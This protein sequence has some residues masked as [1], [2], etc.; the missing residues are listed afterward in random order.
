M[1]FLQICQK[2]KVLLMN[3]PLLVLSNV[4]EVDDAFSGRLEFDSFPLLVIGK[5]NVLLHL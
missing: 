3:R 4:V 2:V 1:Y 5:D